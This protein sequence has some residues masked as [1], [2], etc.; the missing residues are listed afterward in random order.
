[1]TDAGFKYD[2][3][4]DK[5]IC[6]EG[7]IM[8]PKRHKDTTS[9]HARINTCK[10]C[11]SFITCVAKH[12]K[13]GER[14]ILRNPN[15]HLFEKEISR[16]Q[17]ETFHKRLKERMWKIECIFSEAKNMHGLSRAKYRLLQKMQIQAH[18][19]SSVQNLKRL[20][21]SLISKFIR[22]LSFVNLEKIKILFDTQI[23]IIK[24]KIL[25]KLFFARFIKYI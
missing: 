18:M 10:T 21:T 16:M 7:E 19:T 5:C 2:Y 15:Q 4:N 12:R 24:H 20:I 6:P 13:G 9:Y 17:E 22:I 1:M 8:Y 14:V 11:S 25:N 3:E 23:H